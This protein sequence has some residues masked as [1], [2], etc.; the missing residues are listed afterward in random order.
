MLVVAGISRRENRRRLLTDIRRPGIPVRLLICPRDLHLESLPWREYWQP[1]N[2]FLSADARLVQRLN[3]LKATW[4]DLSTAPTSRRRQVAY[5]WRYFGLLHHT[6]EIASCE[7]W[8][9]DP[10][11]VLRC[12]LAFTVF[13]VERM[14]KQGRSACTFSAMNPVYLLGRLSPKSPPPTPRHVPLVLPLGEPHPYYC[15]RQLLLDDRNGAHLLVFPSTD[16]RGS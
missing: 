5:C 14:G 3:R 16:S 10:L 4:Q 8:R 7:P 11:P 9:G 15:Y 1:C 2:A 12:I 13:V 6:L